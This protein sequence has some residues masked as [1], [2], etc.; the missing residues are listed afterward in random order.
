MLCDECQ[1]ITNNYYTIANNN[2][3][4]KCIDLYM[5]MK[6]PSHLCYEIISLNGFDGMYDTDENTCTS[7]NAIFCDFCLIRATNLIKCKDCF[8]L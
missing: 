6:C 4:Q 8:Y 7:C 2:Y 3:C 1:E 5:L